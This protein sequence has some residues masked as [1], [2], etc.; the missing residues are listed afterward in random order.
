MNKQELKLY[1]AESIYSERQANLV[2]LLTIITMLGFCFY[3][4]WFLISNLVNFLYF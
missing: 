4:W 2:R 3:F 1:K